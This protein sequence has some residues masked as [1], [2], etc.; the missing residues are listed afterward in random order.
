VTTCLPAAPCDAAY[1]YDAR[2]R[3]T[4]Y[5]LRAGKEIRYTLDQMANLLGDTTV[6][7]G[8]VTTENRFGT[9]TTR[10]YTAN[11]LT[12]ATLGVNST[13]YWYTPDGNLDCVTK[14]TGS[15]ANCSPTDATAASA[16]P[17]HRLHLRL[18]VEGDQPT[19]LRRQCPHR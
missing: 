7:A 12:S 14:G 19:L 15:Q 8:N 11:Q 13:K 2:D 10:N 5:Q 16:K 3:L 6:R 4:R 9:T 1:D 17:G 18:P